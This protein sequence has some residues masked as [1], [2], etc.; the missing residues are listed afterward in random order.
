MG[1]V[2][3][4]YFPLVAFFFSFSWPGSGPRFFG[5]TRRAEFEAMDKK[6]GVRDIYMYFWDV[7]PWAVLFTFY[8]F[9]RESAGKHGDGK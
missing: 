4:L 8:L 9:L 3:L 6:G 5:F 1:G 7:F 2:A